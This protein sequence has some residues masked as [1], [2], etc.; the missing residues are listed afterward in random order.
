MMRDDERILNRRLAM[1]GLCQQSRED[2]SHGVLGNMI[3]VQ[4][5][6]YATVGNPNHRVEASG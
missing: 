4:D 2:I 1:I 5:L 3:D 6:G